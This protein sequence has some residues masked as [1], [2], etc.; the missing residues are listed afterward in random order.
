MDTLCA[1]NL[2]KPINHL[3]ISHCF[4][5]LFLASSYLPTDI[6]CLGDTGTPSTR[7]VK[8]IICIEEERRA[9]LNFKNDLVDHSGRLS[10]W[11]GHDCC[12]WEGISCDN[13]TGHVVKM[14]LQNPYPYFDFYDTRDEP[15]AY[16][17][18]SCLGGKIN[19]SLLSL[20][21]LNYL[22][23][24]NNFF[25]SNQIPTF[26]GEL[27]SLQYLNLSFAS[28]EGEIPP[29]FGNLSSLNILDFGR[30]YNLSSRNL[31]WLSH[32]SSLK[33]INLRDMNLRSTGVSWAYDIN[34][35]P[36]LESL[37]LSGCSL[38]SQLP[39]SLGMLKSLHHLN[40]GDN[41]LWGSIPFSIGNL[42]SFVTLDLSSNKMNGS[43]PESIG[44]LTNLL[45][46]DLSHN[47]WEAILTE[48]HFINL[49]RLQ[50]FGVGGRYQPV[51]LIFNVAYDWVPPFKLHTIQI[52]HCQISLG[53]WVWLQSQT[54]LSYVGLRGNGISYSIS[55][56]WLSK[57][58]S[59]LILLDLSY[60]QFRGNFPSHLKFPKLELIDLSHNQLEGPLPLW[61]STNVKYLIF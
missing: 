10:S 4:L 41:N 56:E 29:S 45:Y 1:K 21:H 11:V 38:E 19:N 47:S 57:I 14:D 59:Q 26:F 49:T 55:E 7:T 60:N 27:K 22:D 13:R 53:F 24:S 25:R 28:F 36:S 37:D 5:I 34:M 39:A 42:S 43:I 32:L 40:L 15:A 33:S 58:S 23:L 46:L 20:K 3:N 9:L 48:T 50:H 8:S 17:E 54:E 61:W 52:I 44:Q 18:E 51:S 16:D 35:L 31:N 6:L 2:F 12:Q 30:N